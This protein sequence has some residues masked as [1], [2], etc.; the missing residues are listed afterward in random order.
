MA[1][2]FAKKCVRK[3]VWR[4][5]EKPTI[6][7]LQTR[8]RQDGMPEYGRFSQQDIKQILC[9]TKS[10]IEELMPCFKDLDNIGNYQKQY[11]TL[12]TLALYR[13]LIKAN[14][15]SN[16]AINLIGDIIW[17][18]VLNMQG[19]IPV[20]SPLIRKL[21][22]LTMKDPVAAIE[23]SVNTMRKYPYSEPG[24]K[25]NVY[26]KGRAIH[27]DFSSC[28]AADFIKQFGKEE[29]KMFRRTWC[30]LDYALAENIVAG[31]NGICKYERAH[32]LADGDE[33]CD[34]I[35]SICK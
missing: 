31:G 33:L 35:Y 25:A 21:G 14:V 7:V 4:S 27:C 30:T 29:I 19:F 2:E 5:C 15:E 16:Y 20:I 13:S 8:C 34:Q 32:C 12:L 6:Q 28:T 9:Q 10:N 1:K 3:L 22:K 26:R 11:E 23:K 24:Y 18:T 17:V